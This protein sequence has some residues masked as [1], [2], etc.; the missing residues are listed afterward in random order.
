V[1]RVADTLGVEAAQILCVGD[2]VYDVELA[3]NAGCPSVFLTNGD[4]RADV[5][6]DYRI[7]RITE[8]LDIVRR[9]QT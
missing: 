2:Y 6:P 9:H 3:R 1:F 5:E 8:L 7:E 4:D